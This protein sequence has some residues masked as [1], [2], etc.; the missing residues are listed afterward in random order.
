MVNTIKIFFLVFQKMDFKKV[1]QF[2][3]FDE[4]FLLFFW[5]LHFMKPQILKIVPHS[6]IRLYIKCL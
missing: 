2:A 5:D 6:R 4:F 1:D 3:S